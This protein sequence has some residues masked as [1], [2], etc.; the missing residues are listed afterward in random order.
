VLLFV[1]LYVVER[2]EE[3]ERKRLGFYVSKIRT[4]DVEGAPC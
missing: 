4:L 1:L 3:R 2:S